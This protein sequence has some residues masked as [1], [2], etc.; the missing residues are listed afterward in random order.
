MR[1]V[2]VSSATGETG[3]GIGGPV[4]VRLL[5]SDRKAPPMT[6]VCAVGK[7]GRRRYYGNMPRQRPYPSDLSDA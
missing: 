6:P 1:G 7:G 5:L 4:S 3:A 2:G